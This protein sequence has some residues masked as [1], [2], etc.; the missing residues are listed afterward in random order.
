M[1]RVIDLAAPPTGGG[2]SE[3]LAGSTWYFQ[4]WYR[5]PAGPLGNGY[6]LSSSLGISFCP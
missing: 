4:V 3:I 5:D 2:Q 1:V 6:N